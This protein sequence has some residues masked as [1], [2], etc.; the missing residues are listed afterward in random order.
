MEKFKIDHTTADSLIFYKQEPLRGKSGCYRFNNVDVKMSDKFKEKFGKM[1]QSLAEDIYWYLLA[2]FPYE[3][4]MDMISSYQKFS[5]NGIMIDVNLYHKEDVL[6]LDFDLEKNEE[7]KD[8]LHMKHKILKAVSLWS[9]D[10]YIFECTMENIVNFL[11][12]HKNT[13]EM[14]DELNQYL[15]TIGR[16]LK[17]ERMVEE[18]ADFIQAI[19]DSYFDI[20]KAEVE[21]LQAFTDD[22][23]S[24]G[25]YLKM[26]KQDNPNPIT[27]FDF[28]RTKFVVSDSFEQIYGERAKHVQ[29]N[30][31]WLLYTEYQM[32]KLKADSFQKFKLGDRLIYVRLFRNKDGCT[33]LYVKTQEDMQIKIEMLK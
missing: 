15:F 9:E 24:S 10:T 29:S 20:E 17:I 2:T 5:Y 30:I 6:I 33:L 23:T 16:G 14:Y 7:R 12:N 19:K 25:E 1:S 26:Y 28:N 8:V 11:K 4:D 22:I 3:E 31:I 21:Y 18:E 13:Y 27:D 32:K